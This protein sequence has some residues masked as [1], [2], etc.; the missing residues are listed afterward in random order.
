MSRT[1]NWHRDGTSKKEYR[2]QVAK[3]KS[4]NKQQAKRIK[5]LEQL[6][7]EYGRHSAG[8]NRELG[9]KYS[10]RCGWDREKKAVNLEGK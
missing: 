3:L 4:K 6:L 9:D 2:E 1:H 10:C 7:I 5:E 8:C